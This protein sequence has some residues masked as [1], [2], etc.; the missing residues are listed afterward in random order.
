[1]CPTPDS[2]FAD[3]QQIN[4]DLERQLAECRAERDEALAREAALADVLGVINSS[5]GDLAPVFEAMLEKALRRC[6]ARFGGISTYDGERYHQVARRGFTPGFLEFMRGFA[7]I[8]SPVSA[9]GRI[10][11]GEQMIHIVD[12]A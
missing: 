11:N 8:P 5:P 6:D 3:P 10:A 1:M 7:A 12:L 4:A 9:M 2:T